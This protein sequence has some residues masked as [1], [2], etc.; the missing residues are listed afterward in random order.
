MPHFNITECLFEILCKMHALNVF[1][2]IKNSNVCRTFIDSVKCMFVSGL[3]FEFSLLFPQ[4]FTYTC[5][6][7]QCVVFHNTSIRRLD[8]KKWRECIHWMEVQNMYRYRNVGF[9]DVD[10]RVVVVLCGLFYFNIFPPIFTLDWVLYS[11]GTLVCHIHKNHWKEN[12]N[13]NNTTEFIEF[14]I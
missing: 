3:F 11:L 13:N 1:P 9:C 2:L 10:I 14:L 4:V 7:L 8:A 6:Q 5:T 12:N